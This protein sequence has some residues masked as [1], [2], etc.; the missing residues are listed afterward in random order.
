MLNRFDIRTVG[1]RARLLPFGFRLRGTGILVLFIFDY[2]VPELLFWENKF[3]N[4]I[5]AE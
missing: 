4:S 2:R 1:E 5:T 3:K